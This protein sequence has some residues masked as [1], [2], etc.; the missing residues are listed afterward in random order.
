MA[1]VSKWTPFGVALDLSAVAKTVNRKSATQYTVTFQVT[2]NTTYDTPTDYGMTASSGG[3]SVALNTQGNKSQGSSGSFTGTFSINGNGE[4]TKTVTVTF[5]NYNT[6]HS[7]SATKSINLSVSVPAWTSYTVKYNG[8]ASGVTNI[9]SSQTKWK[10]QTLQLSSTEPKRI[11]YTFLEWN[12][13]SDGSGTR[14]QS[15]D[16]YYAN[17]AAT[18]YAVWKANTWTVTYNA[19]GGSGA[20]G[21]QTKTYGVTLKLSS[22]K[23]TRSNY[24]FKGWATTKTATTAQYAAGANYTANAG[25]TLYAVWELAYTKPKIVDFTVTRYSDGSPTGTPSDNGTYAYVSFTWT[26]TQTP[27]TIMVTQSPGDVNV[28]YP[29]TVTSST[30]KQGFGNLDPDITYSFTVTVSDGDGAGYS[31]TLTRTLPGSKFVLDFLKGGNG[32]AIGKASELSGYFDVGFKTR[33]RDILEVNNNTQFYSYAPDGTR[34]EFMHP[35]N[36]NGNVVIGYGNYD[37]GAGNTNIYGYD[38]HIGVSNIADPGY[39][40][41]YRRQGDSIN[42]TLKTAGYVTNSGKDVTFTV[43]FAIPI[44]GSPTVTVSS[45]DGFVLRQ[46]EKYTHGSSAT[47]YVSPDSYTAYTSQWMG[48]TITASFTDTTNVINNNAIGIYWSGTITFT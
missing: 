18:L 26:T 21:T 6:Y 22:T 42:F 2:W 37:R 17:A 43:P 12:T 23:P 5:K 8:N 33:L 7:D 30:F 13:K 44:V 27:V 1:T 19:N 34:V 38:V 29:A 28:T 14:Y 46:G 10:D 48:V 11:G 4:A 9:P 39:Y 31:T 16:G 41:P 32:A 3:G 20:P 36:D 45:R 47:I 40:R 24:N 35:M 15:G 25:A